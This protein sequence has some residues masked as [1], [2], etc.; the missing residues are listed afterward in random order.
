MTLARSGASKL[1]QLNQR[2]MRRPR[3][4]GTPATIRPL[5][6]PPRELT[7]HRV[8]SMVAGDAAGSRPSSSARIRAN[9]AIASAGDSEAIGAGP[10]ARGPAG[11]RFAQ[12]SRNG[13][14]E[15]VTGSNDTEQRP[16][17]I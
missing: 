7:R 1:E 17:F 15:R 2:S 16:N 6:Q 9:A 12:F 14:L 3:L 11:Y 10:R 5:R 13:R 8:K 4:T